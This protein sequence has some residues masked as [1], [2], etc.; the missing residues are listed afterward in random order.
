MNI[1]ITGSAGCG[2][3]AACDALRARGYY[4]LNTD[5]N[6]CCQHLDGKSLQPTTYASEGYNK[7]MSLV[8]HWKAD[9]VV[10][11]LKPGLHSGDLR[12][13]DGYGDNLEDFY[14]YFDVMFLLIASPEITKQRLLTRTSGDWGKNPDELR[15]VLEHIDPYAAKMKSAGAIVIDSEQPLNKVVDQILSH[16]TAKQKA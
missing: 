9:A 14:Q 13:F 7:L 1:L 16:I 11:L 15:H 3:S 6:G 2:K 8:Y 5:S 4:A 10:P 12:F